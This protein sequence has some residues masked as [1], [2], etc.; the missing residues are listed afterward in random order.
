M[1]NLKLDK[2]IKLEILRL[3]ARQEKKLFN[4]IDSL[5]FFDSILNLRNKPSTDPRF[6]DARRDFQQ[7]YI[8]NNFVSK[9]VLIDA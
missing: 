1:K 8:N 3:L 9:M 2:N 5:S 6:A 7:H 4:K